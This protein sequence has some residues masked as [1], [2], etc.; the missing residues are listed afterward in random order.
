ML[1]A[2]AAFAR[3]IPDILALFAMADKNRD[4]WRFH[5]VPPISGKTLA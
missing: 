2:L 3:F 4:E 1:L 5:E